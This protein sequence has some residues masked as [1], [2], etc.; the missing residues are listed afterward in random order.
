MSSQSLTIDMESL[1]KFEQMEK[2]NKNCGMSNM[3][4]R[5]M[6]RKIVTPVDAVSG[7]VLFL[8][9]PMFCVIELFHEIFKYF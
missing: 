9:L 8:F 7:N 2:V 4:G 3:D 6:H 5:V 1:D